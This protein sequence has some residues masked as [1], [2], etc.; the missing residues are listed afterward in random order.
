VGVTAS[1]KSRA[2]IASAWER[3]SVDQVVEVRCGAGSNPASVRISQTVE[4]A[5][6]MPRTRSSPW[7]LR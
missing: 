1:K 6:V 4:A 7:I 3:R 5:T 2:M